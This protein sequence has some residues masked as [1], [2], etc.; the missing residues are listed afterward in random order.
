VTERIGDRSLQHPSDW[1]R[2]NG[3]VPVLLHR[4]S[5]DRS[6][7]H[8]APVNRDGVVDEQFDTNGGK[9]RGRRA[10]GAVRRR[11][12]GEKERRA[13]NR[14]TCDD[15]FAI[16]MPEER[17]AECGLVER[18]RCVPSLTASIG[19]ISVAIASSSPCSQQVGPGTDPLVSARIAT[20]RAAD[21]RSMTGPSARV[22]L[23]NTASS[24][25]VITANCFARITQCHSRSNFFQPAA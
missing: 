7:R 20:R 15:V 21:A 25:G 18:D 23:D 22:T 11:F 14:Q 13:I 6:C 24:T 12:G 17:R 3:V 8:G 1:L 2:A 4:S 19:L 16:E 9:T 5:L 10:A